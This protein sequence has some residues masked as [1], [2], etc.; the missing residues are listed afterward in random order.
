M[1]FPFQIYKL[2]VFSI[3]IHLDRTKQKATLHIEAKIFAKQKSKT[4][5]GTSQHILTCKLRSGIPK[6]QLKQ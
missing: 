4:L 5:S 3:G 1:K 2:H 6:R